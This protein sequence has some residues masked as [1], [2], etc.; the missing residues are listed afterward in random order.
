M[1]SFC[2]FTGN[3]FIL[4]SVSKLTTTSR[5]HRFVSKDKAICWPFAAAMYRGLL[6]FSLLSPW[7]VSMP[8]MRRKEKLLLF[9]L[10]FSQVKIS[11]SCELA[12]MKSSVRKLQ[13]LILR[14]VLEFLEWFGLP[15]II[16]L[17]CFLTR[18]AAR[19][20]MVCS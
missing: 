1:H 18:K 8:Q 17:V 11:L 20:V 12:G 16:R 2:F 3:V 10:F 13:L 15:P 4:L 19:K 5:E 6:I 7:D 14:K 9:A